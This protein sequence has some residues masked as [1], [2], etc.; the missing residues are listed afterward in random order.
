MPDESTVAI[1]PGCG[2]RIPVEE[3][4]RMVECP[5]CHRVVSRM[6]DDARFD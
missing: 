6:D 1:C 2:R 4:W 3:T 5:S